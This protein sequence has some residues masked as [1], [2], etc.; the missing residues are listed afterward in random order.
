MYDWVTLLYTE[1]REHCKSTVI[2]K[3]KILKKFKKRKNY[4]CDKKNT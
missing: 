1:E 4:E 2:E 3:I